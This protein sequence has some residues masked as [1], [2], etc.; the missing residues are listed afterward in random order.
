MGNSKLGRVRADMFRPYT[1]YNLTRVSWLF[2]TYP[3]ILRH[4]PKGYRPKLIVVD[5]DFFMFS[6]GYTEYWIRQ[7]VAPVYGYSFSDYVGDLESVWTQVLYHHELLWKRTDSTGRPAFGLAALGG[8][9]GFLKDGSELAPPATMAKAG[10]SPEDIM[11]PG[12]KDYL[13]GG[14]KMGEAEMAAF[15]EFVDLARQMGIPMVAVQMPM[16]GPALRQLEAD[17]KF[18]ILQ[19]YRNHVAQ[20]Y[21]DRLGIPFFDYINFPPYSEDYRYFIDAAHPG[22]P[23]TQAVIAALAS[24]SRFHALLPRL[25]PQELQQ[26]VIR[27]KTA[28]QHIILNQ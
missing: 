12:W 23:F 18:G 3:D 26:E 9:F 1:F 24:D 13:G 16:Y 19:D 22:E 4:F 20:G 27:E 8:G 2:Y 10:R 25:D 5:A 11:R 21:F 15:K 17:P 6:R 28:N 7:K 14:D